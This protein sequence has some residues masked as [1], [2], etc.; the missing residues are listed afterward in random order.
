MRSLSRIS[1]AVLGTS[2][3]LLVMNGCASPDQVERKQSISTQGG[4][5]VLRVVQSGASPEQAAKLADALRIDPNARDASGAVS[6]LDAAR[7]QY[8]PTRF[9]GTE[10]SDEDGQE[11]T[12]EGFD[13]P[14]IGSIRVIDQATAIQQLTG[15]LSA[16]GLYPAEPLRALPAGHN[17]TFEALDLRGTPIVNAAID[18][19][20]TV[21]A[22]Y[23]E[24]PI[25][26]PGAKISATFDGQGVTTQLRYA[27]R[28]VAPGEAV[29]IVPV[30]EAAARCA[31][32][33]Q[34]G[35]ER[36][37]PSAITAQL[38]YYAPA[39]SQTDVRN[40][41]PY[42]ACGGNAP[43]GGQDTALLNVLIPATDDP[44]YVPQVQLSA[45]AQGDLVT[46]A[47]A[48]QGGQP[49]YSITWAS[50]STEIDS[51]S[52]RIEYRVFS[53]ERLASETLTVTVT[54]ANGVFVSDS[55]TLSV[56]AGASLGMVQPLVG[57]VRDF[58]AE[59]A[60]NNEFGRLDKGF[61]DQMKADGVTQRFV[62]L[63]ANAWERDFK[64]PQD[65]SYI[66]NT[67][68]TFYV[69]HGYGGGFT[70]EDSTHDDDTLYH[71][72]AT[73]AWGDN[74]LEWLA[75]LSC[76]VLRTTWDNLSRFG[77]WKQE[78]DGLHHLLGFNTLAY[79]WSSFSG[80][81]ASNLVDHDMTV[82][83]AWFDAVA[84][85]QPDCVEPVVM[86]VMGANNMSNWN[87]HF[88]GKGSVGPDI[89]GS[90]ITGYWSV[91]VVKQN[92]CN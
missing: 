55:Q 9:L 86:G 49:P 15:A 18:T 21:E 43:L 81:F 63:G 1:L 52:D 84:D 45:T 68:I 69:G 5:P 88:W 10:R 48:I 31:Q 25:H 58:G 40:L 71:T 33:V 19:S 79:A 90:N 74:D 26:G 51:A 4:L 83:Q 46:A 2:T 61:V 60:V 92:P 17:T 85:E 72:N 13:L 7:F 73:G 87:D 22:V 24:I 76:Q 64:P 8:L 28:S 82:R 75:L 67:D 35:H 77:R 50:S 44:A 42:Y 6:F 37:E 70:F 34:A 47:V 20:V 12:L 54:D 39:L 56:S 36:I 65:D 57:G 14:A 29:A 27:F 16:S 32:A 62:W 78:F 53:R 38:V 3:T 89:R 30:E 11:V 59:N 91:R 66:D 41:V 23:E 80:E